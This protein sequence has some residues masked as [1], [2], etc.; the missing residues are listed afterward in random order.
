[1]TFKQQYDEM[2]AKHPDCVLLM[3]R[4]DFYEAYEEDAVTLSEVTGVTLT[5]GQDGRVAA[6]PHYALDSY[7]PRLVRAGKRVAICDQLTAPAPVERVS[8]LYNK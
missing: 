3:R 1:M 6:F 2:K 4:G 8:P 7:L 5:K